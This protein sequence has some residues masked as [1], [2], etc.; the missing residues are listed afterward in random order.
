MLE[1]PWSPE[2]SCDLE[3][4]SLWSVAR[5]EWH[6]SQYPRMDASA[7]EARGPGAGE[8]LGGGA[9][10]GLPRAPTSRS[11]RGS[12][13]RNAVCAPMWKWSC[14]AFLGTPRGAIAPSCPPLPTPSIPSGMR[15]PLCLRR[16]RARAGQGL[17]SGQ[18]KGCPEFLAST[19]RKE[20]IHRGSSLLLLLS[21]PLT[22]CPP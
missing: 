16:W 9:D 20:K 21:P 6:S 13:C 14:L 2:L 8:R 19:Y 4:H 3:P 10:A 11:S 7:R 15:S 5:A 18:G 1:T 17:G 12:S 22:L